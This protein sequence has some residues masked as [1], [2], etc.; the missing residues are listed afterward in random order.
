MRTGHSNLAAVDLNLRLAFEALWA[1]RGLII[2][3]T[4]RLRSP[5]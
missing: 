3:E 4:A 1:E 2:E 5:K